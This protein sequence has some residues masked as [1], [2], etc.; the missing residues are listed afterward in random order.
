MSPSETTD[1]LGYTLNYVAPE[2]FTEGIIEKADSWSF[3]CVLYFL[4]TH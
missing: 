1:V 2:T 3:G 4:F